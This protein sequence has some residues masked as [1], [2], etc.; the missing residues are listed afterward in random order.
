MDSVLLLTAGFGDGHNSAARNIDAA[1]RSLSGG[2]V[3]VTTADLFDE[4]A[5]ATSRFLKWGYRFL[6]TRA[7]AC[8][9]FLYHHTQN[10]EF[11]NLWWDHFMG[12]RRALERTLA[13]VRPAV[14][15]CTYPVYP[16]ALD[17]VDRAD[18]HPQ[19]RF[20]VI[21]DSLS[22]HNVWLKARA[23][24]I[25]V[26]DPRS[27]EVVVA[28]GHD[29]DRVEA[30]G[31][32]VDPEFDAQ[33][34]RVLRPGQEGLRLLY[35]ATTAPGHVDVTI[36]S[37]LTSLPAGTRLTVATGRNESRLRPVVEAAV[38]ALPR[39][40]VDVLGWTSDIPRLLRE[41]DVVI[42]KAGGATV[43]ECIAAEIPVVINCVIPGQEEGNA[44]LVGFLGSGM[45]HTRESSIGEVLAAMTAD[46]RLRAMQEA[47]LRH[48][49]ASGALTI[50]R[51]VLH[52][53]GFPLS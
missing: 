8:W 43:H 29:P 1:I 20:M 24:R 12:L 3:R 42:S 36:R 13:A 15:V 19:R 46:G 14:V 5:P 47:A 51:A 17:L 22:I 2:A 40:P 37:L 49:T 44:D 7:P 50:A 39:I 6:I 10:D 21:T 53:L 34:P 32:P 23:D 11:A 33:P 30:C 9:G 18:L 27:R 26:S 35:F 52:E 28:A 25:F 16:Y 45:R 31:F 48:R 38:R 41:H 4:A